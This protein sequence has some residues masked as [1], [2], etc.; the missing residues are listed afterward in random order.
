MQDTVLRPLSLASGHTAMPK[1]VVAANYDQ[2]EQHF[3]R[4][5][6]TE[7]LDQCIVEQPELIDEFQTAL[8]TALATAYT[9]AFDE[10]AQRFLQRVLYRINRLTLFWY[11]DLQNHCAKL[12]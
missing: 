11:D 8:R 2:A 4:L 1:N 9:N 12:M 6:Q 10:A 3:T 7:N 5:L